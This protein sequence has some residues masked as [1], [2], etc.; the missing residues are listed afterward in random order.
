MSTSV[1]YCLLSSEKHLVQQRKLPIH[2]SVVALVNAFV[3]CRLDY[4]NSLL[5][6]IAVQ[7]M[8]ARIITVVKNK[9]INNKLK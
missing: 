4:W 2:D 1:F 7:T 8:L 9:Q 5:Y 3:Y 6:G